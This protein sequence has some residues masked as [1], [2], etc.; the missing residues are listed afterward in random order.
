[1]KKL[2]SLIL[3]LLFSLAGF[4]QAEKTIF[5]EL[6]V[7]DTIETNKGYKFPDGSF[8][9]T[10]GNGAVNVADSLKAGV[11][12]SLLINTNALIVR[13]T[14]QI[15]IGIALPD[16]SSLLDITSITK[17]FLYPRMTIAQRD[18]ISTPATGLSIFDID[19]NDPNFFNGSAWRRITHAPSSSLK[20]GG[21]IYSTDVASLDNDSANFFWDITSKRLGIG[22]GGPSE[23]LEVSGNIKSDTVKTDALKLNGIIA[24]SIIG[25]NQVTGNLANSTTDLDTVW[26]SVFDGNRLYLTDAGG[27]DSLLIY[28]DGDTTRFESDNPIKIGAGSIIIDASGDVTIGDDLAV[29]G[30]ISTVQWTTYGGT[31][32]I[33]GWTSNTSTLI[34]YKKVGN[35]V[36]VQFYIDGVSDATN[37]TFTL[38]FTQISTNGVELKVAIQVGNNGLPST[39]SGLLTLS[40]NSA[41]VSCF[42]DMAGAI[43][44]ASN[45]KR[46]QGQF[47]YQAQ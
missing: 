35:L 28:D 15:G 37:V 36:F 5:G 6:T 40:P 10:A 46:V 20:V 14:G 27:A 45:N 22:T 31:S 38:P 34:N 29:T 32:T 26:S 21:V 33:V 18:A 39:T 8:Q 30:D 11:T 7:T 3:F 25:L 24:D 9:N 44:T 17:G 47:W 12:D 41:T 43:W 23:K 4:S 13:T 19:N 42:L 16:A 2:L 1:M